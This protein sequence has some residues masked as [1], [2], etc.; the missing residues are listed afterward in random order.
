MK[1]SLSFCIHPPYSPHICFQSCEFA[2]RIYNLIAS[3]LLAEFTDPQ[4][5]SHW[6]VNPLHLWALKS[7][8]ESTSLECCL[9]ASP[10][11]V[12][13]PSPRGWGDAVTLFF[14]TTRK[15]EKNVPRIDENVTCRLFIHTQPDEF[16]VSL[17]RCAVTAT[18]KHMCR[19]DG[20]GINMH[21]LVV[22]TDTQC[23]IPK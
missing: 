19:R 13:E 11:G 3:F 5:L 14:V 7:I 21:G 6:P 17:F 20:F 2:Y 22:N 9:C 1:L 16:N 10:M 15:R 18:T 4:T 12:I 8:R 23:W